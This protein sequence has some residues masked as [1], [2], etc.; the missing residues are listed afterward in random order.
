ML[1]WA[2]G[3]DALAQQYARVDVEDSHGCNAS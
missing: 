1:E 3:M 2:G